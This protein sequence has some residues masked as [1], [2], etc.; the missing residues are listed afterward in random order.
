MIEVAGHARAAS[1][2]RAAKGDV[3]LLE[4]AA[5]TEHAG[6]RRDGFRDQRQRRGVT[7]RVMQR[8]G[9]ARCAIVPLRLD[10]RR[11]AR[12]EDAVEMAK[13]LIDVRARSRALESAAESRP[14]PSMTARMYF[15]PTA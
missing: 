14:A 5:D 11:A 10:I 4:A 3:H 15:S 9:R 6:H 2:Q 7:M 1:D 13:Q 12:E 8:A